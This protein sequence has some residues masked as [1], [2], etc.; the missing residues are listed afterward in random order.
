VR[1]LTE[2]N[3][4]E[5]RLIKAEY[6]L[7]QPGILRQFEVALCAFFHNHIDTGKGSL[8]GVMADKGN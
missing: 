7:R 3:P 1:V 2:P 5:A 4:S 8:V 6:L